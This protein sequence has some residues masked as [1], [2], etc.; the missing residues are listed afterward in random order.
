MLF[1]LLKTPKLLVWAQGNSAE[2][3]VGTGLLTVVLGSHSCKLGH[4][5]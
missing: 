5:V 1:V 3:A 4:P 2:S